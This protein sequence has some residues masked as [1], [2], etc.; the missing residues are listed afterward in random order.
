MSTNEISVKIID[1]QGNGDC[2]YGHKVGEQ[3]RIPDE[4]GKIC[5]AAYYALYPYINGLNYGASFP[6]E[7]DKDSCT[8][9][10]PDYKNS[11]VF[12]ITRK[13]TKE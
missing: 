10:C 1:I 6:W 12:K 3:F 9:G 4:R 7:E 2:S 8:I 11:V 5:S 13:E